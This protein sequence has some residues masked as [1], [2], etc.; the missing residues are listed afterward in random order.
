[1]KKPF[2]E[3]PARIFAHRGYSKEYPENTALAFEKAIELGADVIETDAHLTK[4]GHV[5]IVHDKELS[6]ITNGK[7]NVNE[8]TLH[9]IKQLDAA[10]YFTK[11]GESYPYRGKGITILTLEEMLDVFPNQRFNVDLKDDNLTLAE[12][13]C[14]TVL[15]FKAEHRVLGA[16]QYGK[17]LQYIRNR[18]PVMATS[19]GLWGVLGFYFV[20]RAGL[21]GLFKKFPGDA[22]QIPEYVGPSH[23]ANGALVRMAHERGIQVD[24][25][26]V[27]NERDMRR[28]LDI[29]V[30]GIVTDDVP[31]LKKVLEDYPLK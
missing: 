23:L 25:W 17:N 26:T 31:L 15:K 10:Y 29:D 4:D 6:H 3:K 27:N 20:F 21:L 22:L 30:D 11:D 16:S 13:F 14:D 24:V 2:F 28:L 19:F 18:I 12:K 9:E 1:M 8:L 5:V 7:G